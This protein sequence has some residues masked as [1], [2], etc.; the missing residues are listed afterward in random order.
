MG[1]CIFPLMKRSRVIDR[2]SNELLFT[3]CLHNGQSGKSFGFMLD[4][5][6]SRIGKRPTPSAL[7][8]KFADPFAQW[9]PCVVFGM[10]AAYPS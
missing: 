5:T 6:L 7:S 1:I 2:I 8:I 9:A 10:S 3:L 4:Q